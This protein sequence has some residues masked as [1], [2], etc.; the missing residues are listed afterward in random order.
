VPVKRTPSTSNT[1]SKSTAVNAPKVGGSRG[2]V[3]RDPN[4]MHVLD[5]CREYGISRQTVYSLCQSG[6]LP[7]YTAYNGRRVFR[8]DEIEGIM[9]P[10]RKAATHPAVRALDPLQGYEGQVEEVPRGRSTQGDRK[11]LY[12]LAEEG[13]EG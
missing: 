1:S 9:L 7:Y 12:E 8:R 11:R 6:R 2:R 3:P 10:Y 13:A 4:W 5:L